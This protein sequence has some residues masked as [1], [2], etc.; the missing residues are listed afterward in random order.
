MLLLRR[1]SA[2]SSSKPSPAPLSGKGVPLG[3]DEIMRSMTYTPSDVPVRH[4]KRQIAEQLEALYA[5]YDNEDFDLGIKQ[6]MVEQA[7][8][9]VGRALGGRGAGKRA[10]LC[11]RAQGAGAL[12]SGLIH[13]HHTKG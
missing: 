13:Q 6:F 11:G 8:Q 3:Y 1:R 7:I 9:Q 2:S 10:V 12:W 4:T 5:Q